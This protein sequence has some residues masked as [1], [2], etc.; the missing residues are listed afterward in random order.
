[1]ALCLIAC[2]SFASAADNTTS[3]PRT[4]DELI[5]SALGLDATLRAI[6]IRALT[7]VEQTELEDYQRGAYL[8][9]DGETEGVAVREI[10]D[11]SSVTIAPWITLHL[12]STVGTEIRARLPVEI[13][14]SGETVFSSEVAIKQDISELLDIAPTD[15]AKRVRRANER[16][17]VQRLIAERRIEVEQ[18]VIRELIALGTAEKLLITTESELTEKQLLL[19]GQLA[20]GLLLRNGS[21]HLS[22]LL[23][24]REIE[25]QIAE[26]RDQRKLHHQLL[27]QICGYAVSLTTTRIG[28]VSLALPSNDPEDVREVADEQRNRALTRAELADHDERPTPKVMVQLSAGQGVSAPEERSLRVGVDSQWGETSFGMFGGYSDEDSF[29][30]GVRFAF[31]PNDRKKKTM[32]RQ[33]IERELLMREL[34]YQAA[35]RRAQGEIERLSQ[36]IDALKQRERSWRANAEFVEAYLEE[37][38]GRYAEQLVPETEYRAAQRQRELVEIDRVLLLLERR[39]LAGEIDSAFAGGRR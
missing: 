16:H 12:P 38:D 24:I 36:R 22:R 33:L 4:L 19:E 21:T 1:M 27:N 25:Q 34:Y 15:H 32:E 8:A 29:F 10:G 11:A 26:A 5:S 13:P 31:S 17:V 35:Y 30:A 37:M 3:N 23:E 39:A 2:A 9:I 7:T 28:Y 14:D 6:E 18:E 20:Q